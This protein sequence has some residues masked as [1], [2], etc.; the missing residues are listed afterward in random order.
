MKVTR[1]QEVIVGLSVILTLT[2]ILI[3]VIVWKFTRPSQKPDTQ[4]ARLEIPHEIPN[5]EHHAKEIETRRPTFEDPAPTPAADSP[6]DHVEPN[7]WVAH[8]PENNAAKHEIKRDE[9]PY[10][11]PE[12]APKAIDAGIASTPAAHKHHEDEQR[13]QPSREPAVLSPEVTDD[14][15][16]VPSR[17]EA[18][19]PRPMVIQ[20]SGDTPTAPA[21]TSPPMTTP[22]ADYLNSGRGE[23][24][25]AGNRRPAAPALPPNEMPSA[26]S[27]NYGQPGYSQPNYGAPNNTAPPSAANYPQQNYPQPN[28]A[29]PNSAARD[30]RGGYESTAA[31]QPMDNTGYPGPGYAQSGAPRREE[32]QQ[33]SAPQ[34]PLRSDGMYEVLPN[35][36]YWTISQRV[37]GTGA[38]FRALAEVN[39]GKA[40]RPDRLS[41]GLMISTP[42]VAQLEKDYPDFCPRPNRREAVRNR[43]AGTA[44]LAAYNGGRTYTV[45]EGDTVW[46]IARNE[47]GKVSRWSE[48]VQLNRDTLGKDYDYLTPGMKLVLPPAEG[49]SG[50]RTARR[51][52]TAAPATRY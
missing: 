51:N 52:D 35:D 3:G 34:N 10:R 5:K 48:I 38:Y 45:Q 47:L 43:A 19:A 21:A 49:P 20:V 41:P 16:A 40:A 39:R 24:D 9:N 1:K 46:T 29:M 8:T 25:M 44:S 22:N 2:L 6:R 50:D 37:Y 33:P 32:Y 12:T 15:Y 36:S 42:P 18:P 30:P 4:L 27:G 14:R 13:Y 17:P 28:P 11:V 7:P 26:A 31:A 23:V